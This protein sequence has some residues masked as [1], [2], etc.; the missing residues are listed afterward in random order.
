MEAGWR[1]G[2]LNTAGH[3]AALGRPLGAVPGPISS[4]ASAGC[5]R[6]LREFDAI[7][8]T[9]AREVRELWDDRAP[10]EQQAARADPE[11]IRLT[12]AMSSR[13]ARDAD[14]LARRSGLSAERV[15]SLLG[16]L[17]LEGSVEQGPDGWKRTS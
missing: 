1:S 6:L 12:D 2:T 16:L 15:R 7:C 10:T 9:S 13:T 11:Q 8:V 5:H 4:A 3:A 14:D 17:A